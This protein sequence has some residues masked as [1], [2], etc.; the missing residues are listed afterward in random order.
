[1]K[2]TPRH[3]TEKIFAAVIAV[4]ATA[5]CLGSTLAGYE[6]V[7]AQAVAPTAVMVASNAE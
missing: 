5:L 3:L 4:A 2:T 7:V 1:M 6:Q